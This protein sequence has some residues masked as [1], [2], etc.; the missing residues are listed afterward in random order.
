[1]RNFDSVATGTTRKWVLI[2]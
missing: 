2:D 1:M